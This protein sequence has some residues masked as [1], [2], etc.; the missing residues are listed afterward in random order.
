MCTEPK[1]RRASALVM[2]DCEASEAVASIDTNT[3]NTATRMV[4]PSCSNTLTQQNRITGF[5]FRR[6]KG[7]I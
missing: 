7:E 6:L 5:S 1:C 3:T 2:Q 4:A